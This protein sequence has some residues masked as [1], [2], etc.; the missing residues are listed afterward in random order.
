MVILVPDCVKS[1]HTHPFSPPPPALLDALLRNGSSAGSGAYCRRP[2]DSTAEARAE[3]GAEA[4][5]GEAIAK[6]FTKE[7]VEGVQR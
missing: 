2:P 7:Q 5:A 1:C 3:A 4:R 6:S